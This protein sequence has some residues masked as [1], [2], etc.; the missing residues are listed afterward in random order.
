MLCHASSRI[1]LGQDPPDDLL[2]LAQKWL[3]SPLVVHSALFMAL[4]AEFDAGRK[5]EADWFA[6]FDDDS[7]ESQFVNPTP[8]IE[9]FHNIVYGR[10][11]F[12]VW[13]WAT[14]YDGQSV[15]GWRRGPEHHA[16][17]TAAGLSATATSLHYSESAKNT[18]NV[19]HDL[20]RVNSTNSSDVRDALRV[21]E[22]FLIFFFAGYQLDEEYLAGRAEAGLPQLEGVLGLNSN[23][24]LGGFTVSP[25]RASAAGVQNDLYKALLRGNFAALCRVME[26]Q[27]KLDTLKARQDA[28]QEAVAAAEETLRGLEEAARQTRA[29]LHEERRRL[30]REGEMEF[31]WL[32]AARMEIFGWTLPEKTEDELREL[33]RKA[34]PHAVSGRFALRLRTTASP[35]FDTDL[36]TALDEDSYDQ[37]RGTILEFGLAGTG[38][39]PVKVRHSRLPKSFASFA[40]VLIRLWWASYPHE[41]A[42]RLAAQA[43]RLA[44]RKERRQLPP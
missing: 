22:A 34:D 5:P 27:L 44:Q 9:D 2:T 1:S 20:A 32:L 41:Q 3:F 12:L 35:T 38:K 7:L 30:L 24:A 17:T 40:G 21:W 18:R 39:F 37:F 42:P 19:T 23:R 28:S 15:K 4:V 16:A 43:E 8:P 31:F 11:R 36:A 13:L 26:A 33:C 10:F 25:T 6:Q 29:R 14:I